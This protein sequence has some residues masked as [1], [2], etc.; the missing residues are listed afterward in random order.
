MSCS[1]WMHTVAAHH[2]VSL[3]ES[4]EIARDAR[5]IAVA[6]TIGDGI[7]LEEDGAI[8]WDHGVGF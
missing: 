6:P 3:A 1:G 8:F 4:A 7:A 5:S 2:G